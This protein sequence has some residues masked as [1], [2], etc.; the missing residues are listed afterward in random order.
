LHCELGGAGGGLI[1]GRGAVVGP[2][3]GRVLPQYS[4]IS[5]RQP[6]QRPSKR[7]VTLPRCGQAAAWSPPPPSHNSYKN[8]VS[9]PGR[10]GGAAS[11]AAP[12][13]P[14]LD[15]NPC[16]ACRQR[17]EVVALLHCCDLLDWRT[18]HVVRLVVTSARR[19]LSRAE[20]L[21][22]RHRSRGHPRA[23]AA[24]GGRNA[25]RR[26]CGATSDCASVCKL[27]Q[28]SKRLTHR[29]LHP[30]WPARARHDEESRSFRRLVLA[31]GRFSRDIRCLRLAAVAMWNGARRTAD[32]AER[33][34]PAF[35]VWA[36]SHKEM[37]T[38]PVTRGASVP[39]FSCLPV[40]RQ[41]EEK[42]S[43]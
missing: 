10:P 39:P 5:A 11:C 24:S 9:A 16:E 13:L 33:V 37:R 38:F 2:I 26:W 1:A 22:I 34:G 42:K 18:E 12:G 4:T 8:S 31:G 15:Q 7:R 29:L 28:P 21:R 30:S 43:A 41:P 27:Y 32:T 23:A 6:H 17:R 20:S 3:L 40:V 35:R 14:N 25:H 19:R 36:L